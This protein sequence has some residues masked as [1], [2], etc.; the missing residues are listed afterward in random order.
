MLRKKVFAVLGVVLLM[1]TV[2]QAAMIEVTASQQGDISPVWPS[3]VSPNHDFSRVGWSPVGT[4]PAEE[5]GPYP[6]QWTSYLK[7]DVPTVAGA[8]EIQ[9][10]Q[11]SLNVGV[12]SGS[13]MPIGVLIKPCA[14]DNWT[15]ATL[16]YNISPAAG[17]GEVF[18]AVSG[19]GIATFDV[20]SFL[21][22][23]GEG[24]G[25]SITFQVR[26]LSSVGGLLTEPGTWVEIDKTGTAPS[27]SIAYVPEPAS[28]ICLFAVAPLLVRKNR[29]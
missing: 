19:A 24:F 28:M 16:C 25:N 14:D 5:G 8:G 17:A 21:V 10:A 18:Q 3:A 23:A 6:V 13:T 15:A 20:T 29:K 26:G 9:Q 27:L 11:L 7:F 22:A 4:Y 1:G 12:P 2:C